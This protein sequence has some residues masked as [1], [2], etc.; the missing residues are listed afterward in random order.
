MWIDAQNLVFS[1]LKWKMERE[2]RGDNVE[3]ELSLA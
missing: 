1:P 2:E 3:D